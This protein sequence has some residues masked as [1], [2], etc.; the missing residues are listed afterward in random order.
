MSEKFKFP[1]S[2][3]DQINECSNGGFLLFNYNSNG[4]P[5]VYFTSDSDMHT[6]ALISH[7][8]GYIKACKIQHEEIAM[9]SI[10]ESFTEEDP[11][12]EESWR[13]DAEE[14]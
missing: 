12:E 5:E 6:L 2:L 11:P 9:G 1:K 13:D 3:L 4:T 7:A 8:E 10:Q 14:E